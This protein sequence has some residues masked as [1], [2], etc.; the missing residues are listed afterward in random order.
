MSKSKIA[1][2]VAPSVST[3][4][5]QTAIA[6]IIQ[7]VSDSDA[8]PFIVPS[9]QDEAVINEIL[10]VVDGVLLIVPATFAE[11]SAIEAED[12]FVRVLGR[13]AIVSR[14]NPVHIIGDKSFLA[15]GQEWRDW[16][17]HYRV[18]LRSYELNGSQ[19]DMEELDN[20][21]GTASITSAFMNLGNGGHYAHVS[22]N[23]P[24]THK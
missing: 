16:A 14:N 5:N 7:K 24:V 12:N 6:E 2:V 9:R 11:G 4:E 21:A 19:D 13:K 1:I 18:A 23:S 22:L 17:T 20:F 10:R 3:W 15:S 8:I